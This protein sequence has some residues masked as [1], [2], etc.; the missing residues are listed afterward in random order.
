LAVVEACEQLGPENVEVEAADEPGLLGDSSLLSGDSSF[1][2][3]SKVLAPNAFAPPIAM[4]EPLVAIS[5]DGSVDVAALRKVSATR[6]LELLII[7]PRVSIVSIRAL[8][9][10]YSRI[11]VVKPT[12]PKIDLEALRSRIIDEQGQAWG[13][14]RRALVLEGSTTIERPSLDLRLEKYRRTVKV[15]PATDSRMRRAHRA[16]AVA[17][18]AKYAGTVRENPLIVLSN[19]ARDGIGSK[20]KVS[21]GDDVFGLLRHALEQPRRRAERA[22]WWSG[23]GEAHEVAAISSV[24]TLRAAVSQA[25]ASASRFVKLAR[26]T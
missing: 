5:T 21:L 10:L 17:R 25:A 23:S 6:A 2:L 12:D 15:Y 3:P 20:T 8:L 14:A 1:I 9:H 26:S 13:R 7:A 19:L 18:G 16:L 22:G 11:V 24:A 4:L